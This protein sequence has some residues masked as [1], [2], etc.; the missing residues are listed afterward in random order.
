MSYCYCRQKNSPRLLR[1][2][3][4]RTG[5]SGEALL[6]GGADESKASPMVRERSARESGQ[7]QCV[8]LL[9]G[10]ESI[11]VDMQGG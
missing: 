10:L 11:Y 5:Q 4:Y 9:D 2:R 7:G 6:K 8:T 3:S 1:R